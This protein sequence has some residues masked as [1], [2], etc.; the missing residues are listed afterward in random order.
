MDDLT[1]TYQRG[2]GLAALQH[3]IE[4]ARR[5]DRS[6]VLGFVDVDGL[7]RVNDRTGH[8]AGDALLRAVAEAIR[9][10]LRSY[11]PVV[12]FGGDEFVCALG[13]VDLETA[14]HRFAEISSVL[15]ADESE[16]SISV[17]LAALRAGDSLD[18]LI[19]RA[20]GDLAAD[21]ARRP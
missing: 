11:E 16:G 20:D 15:A 10:K 12:R 6:L 17:G 4:R 19:A 13:D 2:A 9:S 8:A 5:H 3:E 14:R 18:E 7:K 1:G 21:R